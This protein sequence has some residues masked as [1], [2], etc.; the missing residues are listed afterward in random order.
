MSFCKRKSLTG[1]AFTMMKFAISD[2]RVVHLEVTRKT[3]STRPSVLPAIGLKHIFIPNNSTNNVQQNPRK[4]SRIIR[5]SKD[6]SFS[7]LNARISLSINSQNRT[8]QI[9]AES[10]NGAV[11][12]ICLKKVTTLAPSKISAGNLGGRV[13]H[14]TTVTPEL[15]RRLQKSNGKITIQKAVL[16]QGKIASSTMAG[17]ANTLPKNIRKRTHEGEIKADINC[18]NIEA[19]NVKDK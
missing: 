7:Q 15:Y 4:I 16:N 1:F 3:P 2:G 11:Q 18:N 5:T 17:I 8:K 9:R 12:T 14:L 13:V 10:P 6:Q 19:N